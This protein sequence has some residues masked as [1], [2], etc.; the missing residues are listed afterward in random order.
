MTVPDL[1]IAAAHAQAAIAAGTADAYDFAIVALAFS[2]K[3]NF[4]EADALFGRALALEPGNPST[5]TSLAIHYR[6]QS[7]F[8]DAVLACDEAIGNY[9]DYPDAWL[10]RG[11][12]LASGGSNEGARASFH[13]AAELAPQHPAAYAGLAALAAREGRHEDARRFADIALNLDPQNAV[14]INALASTHLAEGCPDGARDLLEPLV[15]RLNVASLERS[16][17]YSTLAGAHDKQSDYAA[18]F[19]N[20][21]SANADFVAIHE[22][23]GSEQ[24]DNTSFVDAIA[25]GLA[26][27]PVETWPTPTAAQPANA[28]ERHIFLIGYPRSGTT[29]VENI[30]ASLPGVSALEERPTLAMTDQTFIAGNRD[31]IIHGINRFAGLDNDA[32]HAHRQA[33]WDK[34]VAA[35]VPS[36]VACFVDMDP[37]KGTR[38]PFIARLFPDARILVMRRDPRDVVWSCFRTNFAMSSGTLEYTNL[39]RAARHYDALMRLT[40][41][42]LE[43]LPLQ[44]HIVQY[45]KIVQDFDDESAAMCAFA[46]LE[47]NESARNFDVTA[48]RRGVTTASTGQ[49]HRGLYDGTKQW[50]P[51][52]KFLEPVLPI[53]QPWIEK[54]GYT[55]L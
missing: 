16:L 21:V 54:F 20:Y 48:K 26:A 15:A 53:L 42:A 22:G 24:L 18:A 41:L 6:N 1:D 38:L 23:S 30:L 34:V 55:E 52:A 47:W 5:L 10:E 11:A 4:A 49:V 17:A 33:Y 39:M 9:P 19:A 35:G 37:L 44:Y 3:G 29:L 40:E 31:D 50:Q 8:R 28:A 12:I 32:L 27:T 43:R 45:H 14:A 46:G 2:A 25:E 7:R 51:Y 13:K 36:A